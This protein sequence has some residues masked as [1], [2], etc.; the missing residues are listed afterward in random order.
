MRAVR[1]AERR[2]RRAQRAARIA[3]LAALEVVG[4][5]V[6]VRVRE[7]FLGVGQGVCV[8]IGIDVVR[9]AIAVHVGAKRPA[10]A[11]FA[12]GGIPSPSSSLS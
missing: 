11:R 1:A 8:G 10:V 9:R 3:D 6:E 5:A 4:H 2:T 12:I 7:P